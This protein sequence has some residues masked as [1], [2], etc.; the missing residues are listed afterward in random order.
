MTVIHFYRMV[1]QMRAFA[2]SIR[3]S[4]TGENGLRIVVQGREDAQSDDLHK[5][6]SKPAFY[7]PDDFCYMLKF[8]YVHRSRPDRRVQLLPRSD[9]DQEANRDAFVNGWVRDAPFRA[10]IEVREA[11]KELLLSPRGFFIA[12]S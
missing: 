4:F 9:S 7:N 12:G 10:K 5:S 2:L 3:L 1:S 6:V 11:I 8:E